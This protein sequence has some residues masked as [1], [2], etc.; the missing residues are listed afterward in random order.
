MRSCNRNVFCCCF[1]LSTFKSNSSFALTSLIHST[2]SLCQRAGESH[3]D[4]LFL[5][6]CWTPTW[7]PSIPLLMYWG[8]SR[9]EGKDVN[10]TL[11]RALPALLS[12]SLTQG[13]LTSWLLSS[14]PKLPGKVTL[15]HDSKAH[16]VGKSTPVSAGGPCFT[17][18][19]HWHT[20]GL[21]GPHTGQGHHLILRRRKLLF[22]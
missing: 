4:R 12:L 1:T 11:P 20:P 5:Q 17:R 21:T 22:S 6:L 14:E 15:Q 16:P 3:G 9:E 10:H 18:W 13:P 19:G 8:N 7:E 2:A